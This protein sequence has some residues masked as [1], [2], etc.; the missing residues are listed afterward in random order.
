MR[1]QFLFRRTHRKFL[2]V[3]LLLT[4]FKLTSWAELPPYVYKQRQQQAPESLLIKVRSVQTRETDEPRG[5]KIDVSVEAQVEQVIRSQT[6]LHP[7][8]VIRIHYAH[9]E[10]KEPLIGPS[11]VPMLKEGERCP[12]YLEMDKKE[13]TYL[14]AAGGYSFRELK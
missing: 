3:V 8:D 1:R 12:A 14:P 4:S 6:G 5:K 13:K 2:L 9:N 7:G 11:E 10:Y